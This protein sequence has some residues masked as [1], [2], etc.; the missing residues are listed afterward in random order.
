[1][2]LAPRFDLRL[3]RA[4]VA[5]RD[6]GSVTAAARRLGISQPALSR[7]LAQLE[8]EIGFEL[9]TRERRRLVPAR[10]SALFLGRAA[11]MV[12]EAER[13]RQLALALRN[14]QRS[15]IRILGVP[16]L[17]LGLLQDALTAFATT[18]P[19]MEMQVALRFRTDLLRE[20]QS[21][22]ADFGLTVLPVDMAGLRA[23]AFGRTEAVCLLPA[24][25]P[26]ARR[27]AITP[28]L[29]DG[30]DLAVLAEGAILKQWLDEAFVAA[31]ASYRRR[32]VVDSSLMAAGYVEAGLCCAVMHPLP[33]SRV[34]AGVVVRPFQPAIRLTYAL[35]ERADAGLGGIA[36]ALEGVLR[37]AMAA[38]DAGAVVSLRHD[39]SSETADGADA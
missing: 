27:R 14:G 21:G 36:D 3:L 20:L 38:I 7:L 1:M 13:M 33:A 19:E 37:L 26:L 18:H 34:P 11:A 17:A 23:R 30:L 16:N 25:H 31:G 8:A 10:R 35:L 2:S 28:E 24:D 39:G 4:A 6:A 5:V 15:T 29:L 22:E 32:F 12:T 9:F